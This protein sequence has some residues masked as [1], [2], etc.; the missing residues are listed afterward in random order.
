MVKRIVSANSLDTFTYD[1]I[2]IN[3]DPNAERPVNWY[4]Q[5]E[6]KIINGVLYSKARPDLKSRVEPTAKLIKPLTTGAQEIYV[7]NAYPLFV[8]VDELTEDIN[9]VKVVDTGDVRPAISS[10]TVSAAS[11]VSGVSII[12][13]GKGFYRTTNPVVAISSAIISKK[14]PIYGWVGIS[15]NSG[16]STTNTFNDIVIGEPIVAV[17]SS[18]VLGISTNGFEWAEEYIGY[19]NTINFNS[20]AVAA[21]STFFAAGNNKK[22]VVNTGVNTGFTSTWTELRLLKETAVIGLPDPVI[23]FSTYNGNF[24]SVV[25]SEFHN[26]TVVV[27]DDNGIFSGVGIGTTS[28]FERTPPTFADYSAVAT[29]GQTF[30]GVGNNA[31]IIYSTDGGF[32]KQLSHHYHQQEILMM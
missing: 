10:A 8:D 23:S 22:L 1:S 9:N 31:T 19:G 24:F 5:T 3:T 6:D 26:S 15:T 25:H 16:I 11:T 20:V 17:G 29:N 7:D 30:V 14:D 28:F 32:I 21:T 27:G 18:G 2:G 13:G 4:K 12:D